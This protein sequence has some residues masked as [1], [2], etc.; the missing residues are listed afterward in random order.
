[1]DV[2]GE[3]VQGGPQGAGEGRGGA[4]PAPPAEDARAGH[5]VGEAQ[6]DARLVVALRAQPPAS[7]LVHAGDRAPGQ[8]ARLVPLDDLDEAADLGRADTHQRAVARAQAGRLLAGDLPAR[9]AGHEVQ[10]ARGVD[11]ELPHR[12]ARGGDDDVRLDPHPITGRRRSAASASS[13]SCIRR[14]TYS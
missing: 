9:H 10:V 1:G 11:D 4:L 8:V 5:A 7:A 6:L 14:T 3:L 2:A 12:L 13:V